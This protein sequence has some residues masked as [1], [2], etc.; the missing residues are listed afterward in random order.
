M[1]QN[2]VL[3]IE[4]EQLDENPRRLS[5]ELDARNDTVSLKS[6]PKALTEILVESRFLRPGWHVYFA[7]KGDKF[8]YLEDL[9][10]AM[11]L[12]SVSSM[13]FL[14]VRDYIDQAAE[15][16]LLKDGGI[17]NRQSGV[18]L[19]GQLSPMRVGESHAGA[20]IPFHLAVT[21][22]VALEIAIR[23]EIPDLSPYWPYEY[24]RIR[25]A[26]YLIREFNPDKLA[27]LR[28]N[29]P[30]FDS[31]A[32]KLTRQDSPKF[33]DEL[34]AGSPVTYRTAKTLKGFIDDKSA[35][36]LE[37]SVQGIVYE[38]P[39]KGKKVKEANLSEIV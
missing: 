31:Q 30:D 10:R 4:E 32:V 8:F 6:R 22:F 9:P 13:R 17:F 1:L 34:A 26:V 24:L 5:Q 2:Q 20:A 18:V 21:I 7:T 23:E 25:P 38:L 12:F 33:L 14:K 11:S 29:F 28:A 15:T 27:S 19:S 37:L 16:S 3:S 35:D 36:Q 39:N